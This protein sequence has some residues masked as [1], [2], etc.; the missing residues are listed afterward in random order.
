[1][2]EQTNDSIDRRKLL[3]TATGVATGIALS[4]TTTLS[5]DDEPETSFV[6]AYPDRLSYEPGDEV[7][8]CASTTTAR[9][10]KLLTPLRK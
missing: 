2:P 10:D 5:A 4:S 6:E 8:L 3:K 1:M 7:A 9:N